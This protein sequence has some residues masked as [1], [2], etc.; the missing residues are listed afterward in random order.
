MKQ[1]VNLTLESETLALLDGLNHSRMLRDELA[2]LHY[3]ANGQ[4]IIIILAF[5]DSR[6][7]YDS[8]H[9]MEQVSDHRF[10]R[11]IFSIK[12]KLEV[13]QISEVRWIFNQEMLA[14]PLTA[15]NEGSRFEE[16]RPGF[17][18]WKIF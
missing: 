2:D 6:Q 12:E 15:N 11:D 8:V 3:G 4:N 7:L 5:T 16:T 9:S 13:C 14:N 1:V 10:R 18:H 17:G